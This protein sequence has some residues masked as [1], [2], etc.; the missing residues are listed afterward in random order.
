MLILAILYSS[1]SIAG[2]SSYSCFNGGKWWLIVQFV[3]FIVSK[4]SLISLG[5]VKLRESCSL[6]AKLHS[7]AVCSC[8]RPLRLLFSTVVLLKLININIKPY[9]CK[10]RCLD[11]YHLRQRSREKSA[12]CQHSSRE[13][14][15]LSQC[16]EHDDS[17]MTMSNHYHY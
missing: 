9:R 3:L 8:S 5:Y 1:Y 10:T 14:R 7:C 13:P 17:T 11:D 6:S 16:S 12:L 4:Y 15:Q 2:L